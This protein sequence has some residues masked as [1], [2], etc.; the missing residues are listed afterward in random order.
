MNQENCTNYNIK[1]KWYTISLK[2]IIFA[3]NIVRK[4]LSIS[5]LF[6]VGIFLLLQRSIPHHHHDESQRCIENPH[7]HDN[8]FISN[9]L[10]SHHTHEGNTKEEHCHND[11][12]IVL[13]HKSN[14]KTS[15]NCIRFMDY[16]KTWKLNKLTLNFHKEHINTSL[17][18]N[19]FGKQ[20]VPRLFL[21]SPTLKRG[22]P[23]A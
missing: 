6:F 8:E 17:A 10:F 5:L 19:R 7:F 2:S 22:P 12:I 4:K 3:F 23:S 9:T 1:N 20:P 15:K 13:S 11:Q 14:V 21:F 16:F 18:I